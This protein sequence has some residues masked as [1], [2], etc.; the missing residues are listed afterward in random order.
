MEV[1]IL[2]NQTKNELLRQDILANLQWSSP[3][4][5]LSQLDEVIVFGTGGAGECVTQILTQYQVNILCYVDNDPSRQQQLFHGKPV[6]SPE[7]LKNSTHLV[8][9]ASL[10][11]RDIALQLLQLE[12]KYLDFSFCVD[13]TRWKDHFNCEIF[14]A[15]KAVEMGQ[16]HLAGEDLYSFL[17][18]I[19]YRQ[20]YD[21][22]QLTT[23]C[24]EHYMSSTVAPCSDD[25]YIDG[26]AWQ[27][28]TLLELKTL[29]GNAIE[30]HSFEP[31]DNNRKILTDL[32]AKQSIPHCYAIKK[33]LWYQEDKLNFVTSAEA[34]HTMQ[35]RVSTDVSAHE[36]VTEVSATT[37]D[38]YAK[39]LPRKPTYIK[40]DIEGAEPQALKGAAML[41]RE[42]PP[43]LAISAYHEPNHLWQ[44][45]E[46]IANSNSDYHFW[47][48]HHSQHLFESVIYAKADK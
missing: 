18:C 30:V 11:A 47:F 10:W 33:A 40:L 16:K 38:C 13:F 34:V 19:R 45:I 5:I 35:S 21:P 31:D 48:V 8:L 27:G 20:T 25:V 12:C 42:A 37:I 3:E 9:I 2:G 23:P 39:T 14:D 43:K 36:Q 4:Q 41:M 6:I 29:C 7:Q 24:H 46:Q 32:I 22:L 44:L 26:G 15:T 1:C 28:D 17:G